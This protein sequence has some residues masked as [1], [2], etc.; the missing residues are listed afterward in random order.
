MNDVLSIPCSAFAGF[1]LVAQGSVVDVALA[2]RDL[3]TPVDAPPVLIFD[4][5]SGGQIDLNLRGSTADVVRRLG[6][7]PALLRLVA[8]TDAAAVEDG[9]SD[10]PRGRGRPK[11]G[12]VAREVTLLP[13]H[14]DWLAS[15]PGGASQALRRLVDLARKRD[16]GRTD[17]RAARERAYRFISAL[18]GD[19][20]DFETAS[21]ALFAGDTTAFAASIAA[22]P[23]DVRRHALRLAEINAA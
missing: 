8:S 16:A 18:A 7:H 21:R 3:V 4:D 6:E 12:V 5:L 23:S 17:E 22:W 19:L 15:Q 11:L 13:R 1:S 2:L 9:D 14:W 10:A 20:P